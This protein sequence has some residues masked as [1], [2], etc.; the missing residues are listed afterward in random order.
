M[1]AIETPSAPSS[2]IVASASISTA[3]IGRLPAVHA[4]SAK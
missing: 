2:A 3:K 4:Q 1:T